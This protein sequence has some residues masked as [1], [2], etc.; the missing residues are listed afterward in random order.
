M[1]EILINIEAGERRVAI[2]ASKKLEWYFVERIADK[3]IVGNI[4]KGKVGAVLEGMGAAF[5]DC[6]LEKN[7]FLYVADI[8]APASEDEDSELFPSNGDTHHEESSPPHVRDAH[9]S[10]RSEAASGAVKIGDLL[11]KG[12]DILVQIVKEELGTKGARLT[13][14]I[15]LPGRYLVLMPMSKRIG[16][17]RRIRDDQERHRIK[18]LLHEL[19]PPKDMGLVARTA[20]VGHDKRDFLRD[21]NYLID[22][23]SRVNR[24]AKN[25]SAPSLVFEELDLS[26]KII[27]D[28]LTDETQKVIVDDKMEFKRLRAFASRIDAK[29]RDKI[30]FYKEPVPLFEKYDIEKE[31]DKLFERKIFLKCGG[32]ITVEQTEGMVAIDVN[33]GKFTGRKNLEDTVYK[34]N[35]EAAEEVARQIRLRDIGGIIVIDFIDME[36]QHRRREVFSILQHALKKD[37][38]KTQVV[39]MSDLDIVE[40]T[41]QRVRRS[42]ESVSYN[43]CPYCMGKGMVKSAATMVIIALRKLKAFLRTHRS[44]RMNVEI[45]VHPYVAQRLVNEDAPSLDFL[46]RSFRGRISVVSD[47]TLHVEDVKIEGA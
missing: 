23:Y 20:A 17:S 9:H 6:G 19:N 11:K 26:C 4:Y 29:L 32:Y 30:V 46:K 25:R 47:D 27:R 36:F 18:T 43:N 37:R 13:T 38:A 12:Q 44:R 21:I 14:H 5:I 40:M 33:S 31:I 8:T 10:R 22:T 15:T 24:F 3:R 42:L 28:F 41:R 35:C 16:V 2:L 45:M 39:S 1:Q 7:G 34:V